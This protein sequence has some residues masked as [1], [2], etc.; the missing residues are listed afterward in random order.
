MR[1]PGLAPSSRDEKPRREPMTRLARPSRRDVLAAGVAGAATVVAAPSLA[2]AQAAHPNI[3]FIMAD[4]LGYADLSCYGRRDYT[5]P[6]IDRLA[7]QGV[8]FTQAYAN[9]AVCSATRVALITGRYQYRLPV[10]LEKPLANS[11]RNI[12]LPPAHPTLPS[13]L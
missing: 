6:N 4:D 11:P 7:A 2:R 9:S 5:T 3:I 1:G 12:G 10:G 13:L 8:R